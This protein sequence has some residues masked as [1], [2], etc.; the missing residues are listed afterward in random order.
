MSEVNLMVDNSEENEEQ[1]NKAVKL[2]LNLLKPTTKDAL[3]TE[4]LEQ[5]K[6]FENLCQSLGSHTS[7]NVKRM[8][9]IEFYSL[10]EI[11]KTKTQTSKGFTNGGST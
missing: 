5:E 8:K 1:Y 7:Q 6:A 9:A 4:I 10:L 11:V 3:N 2:F